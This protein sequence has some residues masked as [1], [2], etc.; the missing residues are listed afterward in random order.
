MIT[1]ALYILGYYDRGNLGDEAYKIA[2]KNLFPSFANFRFVNIDGAE[3]QL[4]EMQY[5][6]F[7]G[8]DLINE[9]FAPTLRKLC[10]KL[11]S[12][13]QRSVIGVSMGISYVSYLESDCLT[14]FDSLFLRSQTDV[15]PLQ[16]ILGSTVPHYLPDVTFSLEPI[17]IPRP[18]RSRPLIGVFLA[19]CQ[20]HQV[21]HDLAS[22]LSSLAEHADITLYRFNSGG[23][24]REDD[25]FFNNDIARLVAAKNDKHT[26]TVNNRPYDTH[27]MLKKISRLDMAI[28]MRYH[29][30]IFSMITGTPFVSI[31]ITRKTSLLLTDSGLT[32]MCSQAI[33][34][35]NGAPKSL[36]VAEIRAKVHYCLE[37]KHQLGSYVKKV[38]EHNAFLLRMTQI[39]KLLL[40]SAKP[41][42][43]HRPRLVTEK[44][45]NEIQGLIT[46]R[47][48]SIPLIGGALNQTD[49]SLIAG[50]MSMRITGA[51]DSEYVYGTVQNLLE[52]PQKLPDMIDWMVKDYSEK[53][54]LNDYRLNIAYMAQDTYQGLHRSGW[55]FAMEHMRCLTSSNGVLC[56]TFMDRTFN[57][58]ESAL[59]E[60]GII[61]YTSPWVGF[62]HHTPLVSYSAFSTTALFAKDSFHQSLPTCKGIYV[63]S[64][65]LADWVRYKL[66]ELDY[67]HIRVNVLT[68]PTE[69]PTRGFDYD[70]FV[71]SSDRKIINIGAWLRDPFAIHRISL[72]KKLHIKKCSLRG[73]RMESYFCPNEFYIDLRTH[74]SAS[75]SDKDNSGK[76]SHTPVHCQLPCRPPVHQHPCRPQVNHTNKWVTGLL[77][78]IIEEGYHINSIDYNSA[79]PIRNRVRIIDRYN[80]YDKKLSHR[81]E[82]IISS[83]EII[84]TL[85]NDKYDELLSSNIV[86]LKLLDCSAVNTI[87]ECVVRNTPIVIN[88]MTPTQE[89]LGSKY[90]LFYDSLD[91]IPDLVTLDSVRAAH[92][93]LRKLDKERFRIE[94]FIRSIKESEIYQSL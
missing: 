85:P 33:G 64:E 63:L 42:C 73:P 35:N 55:H 77:V 44:I 22:L 90:P 13:C 67:A 68:H 12:N 66:K 38:A 2:M 54:R 58:A 88:R 19:V 11:K 60:Q 14:Y 4:S 56:D 86:F 48:G 16:K 45:T 93:Y 84:N 27:K 57:W 83:V 52:K 29:S 70:H 69:W 24:P 8:G 87:I 7:G 72:N 82:D 91:E 76:E 20:H 23:E 9:Y 37:N 34:D 71:R 53:A 59:L 92:D 41:S 18:V 17:V 43:L 31:G 65:Y 10:T 6:V 32:H 51:A 5:V 36:N 39:E 80:Q 46:R 30:H 3:Q 74:C 75:D 89:I 28:C 61:P 26:L 40:Q 1:E 94:Y 50:V 21:K 78:Y 81:L 25:S 49:A 62:L 79:R 47:I 15:R